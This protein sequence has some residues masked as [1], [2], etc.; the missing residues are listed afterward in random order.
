M[1]QFE[2]GAWKILPPMLH[3]LILMEQMTLIISFVTFIVWFS[4]F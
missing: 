3:L 1:N 4:G 2:F